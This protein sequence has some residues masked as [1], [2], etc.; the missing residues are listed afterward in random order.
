MYVAYM[1]VFKKIWC[2]ALRFTKKMIV[3]ECDYVHDHENESRI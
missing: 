1:Y 2:R 3:I